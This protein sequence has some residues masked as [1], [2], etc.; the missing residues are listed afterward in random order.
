M[1]GEEEEEE[2][3]GGKEA[4]EGRGVSFT[5]HSDFSSPLFRSSFVGERKPG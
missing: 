5:T 3:G 2:S 4:V 1:V